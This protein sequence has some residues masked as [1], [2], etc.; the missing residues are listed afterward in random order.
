MESCLYSP[1]HLHSMVLIKC[2]DNL[3]LAVVLSALLCYVAVF[4][5]ATPV[6]RLEEGLVNC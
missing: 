6:M 3:K 1:T 2:R 4:L 5:L